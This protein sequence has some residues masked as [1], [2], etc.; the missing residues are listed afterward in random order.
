[1]AL[2]MM[3]LVAAFAAVRI[4]GSLACAGSCDAG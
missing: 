3:V 1:M 2:A 4:A